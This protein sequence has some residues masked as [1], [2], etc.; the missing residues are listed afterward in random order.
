MSLIPFGFDSP[1]FV[2]RQTGKFAKISRLFEY[3]RKA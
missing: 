3:L 2:V 1:A